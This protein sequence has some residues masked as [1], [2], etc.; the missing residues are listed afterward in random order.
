MS[1]AISPTEGEHKVHANDQGYVGVQ[2]CIDILFPGGGISLRHF[3][4]LLSQ[5]YVP[6]LRLGRRN[7]FNPSEV[8]AALERRLKRKAVA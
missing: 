7:L 3:N 5:G 1:N 8:R 6:Y 4:K 2:A